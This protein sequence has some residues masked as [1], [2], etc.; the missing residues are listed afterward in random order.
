MITLL[1]RYEINLKSLALPVVYIAIGIVSYT[2]LKRIINNIF[3]KRQSKILVKRHYQK[4]AD[5]IRI[6]I[7]NILKYSIIIFVILGELT[8]FGINIRSIVAGLGITAAVLGLAFQDIAKD[9]LAG[10]FIIAE[11]Q[12]EIGDTIE[13]N[14][15]MGEVIFIGL[16][17]TRLRDYKGRTKII[18]NHSITE[19]INYNLANNLAVV[20]IG[21]DYDAKTEDVEKVLNEV[22]SSLTKTLPKIKGEV[23]VLGIDSLDSSAVVYRITAP[24]SSLEQY[25][26]QR[27]MRKEIKEALDKA[28]IK[29]PFPQVEVHSGNES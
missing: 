26:A 25:T 23:K 17:T 12:Y 10:I 22:A 28:G 14:G 9:L 27:I 15:F 24:V 21:V 16:K 13:V 11:D 4:R 8:V 6:M 3:K 1:D 20:D 29:I 5:T 2:I 7:L 18:A 19:V